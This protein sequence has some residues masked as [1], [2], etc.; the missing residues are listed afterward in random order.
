MERGN[1]VVEEEGSSCLVVFRLRGGRI[2]S[3][4]LT[5]DLRV[6]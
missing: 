1:D 6:E 2:N 3:L 4:R 5:C